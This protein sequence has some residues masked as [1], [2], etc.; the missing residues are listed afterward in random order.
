MTATV[1]NT[2]RD[3]FRQLLF[4][5]GA[6][7]RARKLAT[8]AERGC[9]CP[10]SWHARDNQM[11]ARDA[12]KLLAWATAAR[13]SRRFEEK[14]LRRLLTDAGQESL[15]LQRRLGGMVWFWRGSVPARA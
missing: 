1:G 3:P 10:G 8:G 7:Y 15:T 12:R 5:L 14:P 13:C 6:E 9:A 4:E 11:N 2:L